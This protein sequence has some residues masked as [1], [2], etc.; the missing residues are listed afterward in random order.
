MQ[1]VAKK[2]DRFEPA[3]RYG[4]IHY[5]VNA[6]KIA[7]REGFG[8]HKAYGEGDGEGVRRRPWYTEW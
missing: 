7:L 5:N 2:F 1:S 6:L 8:Q 4:R 3:C